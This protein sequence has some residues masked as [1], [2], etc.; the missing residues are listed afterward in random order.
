M[1]SLKF[2]SQL[3]V[4]FF[5]AVNQPNGSLRKRINWVQRGQK[6]TFFTVTGGFRSILKV[7]FFTVLWH[8][9]KRSRS[10]LSSVDFDPYCYFICRFLFFTVR[11]L[12]M[13]K[14]LNYGWWQREAQLFVVIWISDSARYWKVQQRNK[15]QH[16][17]I[18]FV[19]GFVVVA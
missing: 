18:C 10:L 13:Y 1:Q 12:P 5:P 11:W 16:Y 14:Y 19:F 15:W 6:V 7:L 3:P 4:A 2:K 8:R 9:V 17:F